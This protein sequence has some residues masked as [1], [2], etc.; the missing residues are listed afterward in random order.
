MEFQPKKYQVLNI[1][2]KKKPIKYTCTIHGH[3]LET[4]KSA[5][6][7]GVTHKANSTGTR[8]SSKSQAKQT[9][10]TPVRQE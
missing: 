8:M 5:K 9:Q 3:V 1:T 2:N 4:V 7:L 10:R 6:Y